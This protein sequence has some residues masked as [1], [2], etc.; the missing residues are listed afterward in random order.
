MITVDKRIPSPNFTPGRRSFKPE[1]IV[2]HIM[3]G[4]LAG[5]D[6]WFAN[7]ASK[8]SAHFGIG[9]NGTLHQ[10]VEIANTAWHSGRVNNP[11][12]IG[13]KANGLRAYFN[14]NYYT[15][16]IE[17]EGFG[18]TAWTSAMYNKS[19]ELIAHLCLD[20]HIP[21]DRAHIVGHHE[22]YSVKS[23]P[24]H[25]VDI[26]SLIDLAKQHLTKVINPASPVPIALVPVA[27]TL[28]IINQSGT[29]VVNKTLNIREKSPN[30][31]VKIVSQ[32][33]AGTI[34]SY[35][36]WVTDGQPVNGNRKWYFDANGD[37]FWSG[38]TA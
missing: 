9:S 20:H 26:N 22:I 4:T 33:L 29:V 19:A 2:I 13:I 36:G 11:T 8:V 17:H 32:A 7:R 1:A 37:Y 25:R 5:T 3:E 31:A 15:I 23:C 35:N 6:S 27:S 18:M 10:Y 30:T 28:S 14:P 16:G 34:L 38:A 21:L 24:G 12:W